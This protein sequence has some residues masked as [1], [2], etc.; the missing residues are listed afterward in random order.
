MSSPPR[1]LKTLLVAAGTAVCLAAVVAFGAATSHADALK[2]SSIPVKSFTAVDAPGRTDVV[3]VANSAGGTVSFLDGHTFTNLGSVNVIPDLAERLAGMTPIERAGYEIVKAQKGGDRFVDDIVVNPDGRTLVVSRAN[4]ADVVA[5]DLVTRE[6]KWR[7]KVDGLHADHMAPSPDGSRVVVSATTGQKAHVLDATT[8]RQVTT[9]GAGAYPHGNDFSADG[10]R[11]YNSSIGF[12]SMPKALNGLKG[13]RQLTV[14]DARTYRKIR[15]Y[16][17]EYGIRPAVFTPDDKIMYAQLSYLN[18]FVEYDL[19]AG[20]ILRTVQ[21]PLAG[22]GLTLKPD[23]YP[24][25]SAHHGLAMSG[26]GSKLCDAGTIDNYV[27]IVSRPGLTTDRII[28]VGNLPY[29]AVTSLDG[30]HC[31]VTQSK[32]NVLSV[33]SYGTAQEVKRVPLGNFPQRER[34][35]KVL[36]EVLPT[37]STT[38]G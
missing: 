37:L 32:D 22:P 23:E 15:T 9:F 38:A 31:L 16:D 18:G 28:P 6:L 33:I 17:F 35:A 30:Q 13:P 26:D 24:Q 21:M 5:F 2:R 3:L 27:A 19:E 8:G 4:L 14:V 1:R 7:F 10:T 20:K 12:T 29:W 25:N 11:L 34:L 36:T